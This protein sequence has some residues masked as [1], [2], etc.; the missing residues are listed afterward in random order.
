MP[1]RTLRKESN[2]TEWTISHLT[3]T[4]MTGTLPIHTYFLWR[5][6]CIFNI[7]GLTTFPCFFSEICLSS[8]WLT[9]VAD[10]WSIVFKTTS[11]VGSSTT[12]W[13]S[14]CSRALFIC[15]V[16]ARANTT[17]RADW[18]ETLGCLHVDERYYALKSWK[19]MKIMEYVGTTWVITFLIAHDSLLS[20]HKQSCFAMKLSF[21]ICKI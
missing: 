11:R 15:V 20:L 12:W 17:C 13:T 8:K 18:A 7:T 3:P 19:R 2:V 16:M 10:S 6:V 9:S 21:S 1:W 14:T 5:W 4:S